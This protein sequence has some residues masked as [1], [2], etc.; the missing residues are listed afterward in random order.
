MD[1]SPPSS[2]VHGISQARIQEWVAS[3]FSR[4]SSQPRD[5]THI[6][7][8]GRQILYHWATREANVFPGDT[9]TWSHSCGGMHPT[10]FSAVSHAPN[11]PHRW[12]QRTGLGDG[13]LALWHHARRYLR[14]TVPWPFSSLKSVT[15]QP[16]W[17]TAWDMIQSSLHLSVLTWL[18]WAVSLFWPTNIV[19]KIWVPS[20][21]S[22]VLKRKGEA[23]LSQHIRHNMDNIK[24]CIKDFP[25]GPVVKTAHFRPSH[26]S[27]PMTRSA[28]PHAWRPDFSGAAREYRNV[29]LSSEDGAKP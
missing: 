23:N 22:T 4:G 2:S 27:R 6:S 25:G 9:A 29:I 10:P 19:R 24:K 21:H 7:C 13:R 8:I 20:V 18:Y 26:D 5:W 16:Q 17:K 12:P 28:W 15:F 14:V 1:C 11:T 3:F